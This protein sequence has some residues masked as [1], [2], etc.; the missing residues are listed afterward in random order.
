MATQTTGIGVA[1]QVALGIAQNQTLSLS[2]AG[3]KLPTLQLTPQVKDVAGTVV[4]GVAL[5]LT[6]VATSS[7]LTAVYTG[8]IT[9][10]GSNAFKGFTFVITGFTTSANNGTFECTASGTTT[11]TLTN[12][13]A[14]S[15]THAGT[16]TSS[17][18]TYPFVFISR[19]TAQATVSL[20]GLITSVAE[21]GAV[22]EV[23]YPFGGNSEGT[24][25]DGTYNDKI[26][27]EV[28]VSVVV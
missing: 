28:N 12:A 26:Y 15:E 18:A 14:A 17:D 2:S 27:A 10:G 24:A 20:S 21:G 4:T 16:A 7:G 5:T 22:I 19:S 8:T 25:N 6:A 3:G 9:G 11:L 1:A 13:A 23:S